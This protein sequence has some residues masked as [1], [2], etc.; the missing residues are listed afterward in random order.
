[1]AQPDE[2]SRKLIRKALNHLYNPDYLRR[3]PLIQLVGIAGRFDAPK[4][5]QRILIQ[6]IDTVQYRPAGSRDERRMYY[7]NLLHD[8]YVK[9]LGQEEVAV[10]LGVSLRQLAREQDHAVDILATVLA[11]KY[12]ALAST[13]SRQPLAISVQPPGAVSADLS[14]FAAET[15]DLPLRLSCE[16]E[17]ITNMIEPLLSQK[18]ISVETRLPPYTAG[19]MAHPVALRQALLVSIYAVLRGAGTKKILIEA[20]N[21][22]EQVQITIRAEGTTNVGNLPAQA[23]VE[24]VSRLVEMNG[25]WMDFIDTNDGSSAILSLPAFQHSLLLVID[26]DP[27]FLRFVEQSGQGSCYRIVSTPEPALAREW[28]IRYEIDF[29]MLD[30]MIARFD[31]WQLLK[32]L[33]EHPHAGKIPVVVCST[34]DLEEVAY[35]LGASAFLRKP[36]TREVLFAT[37][38]RLAG[39]LF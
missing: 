4:V 26:D 13:L 11:E 22:G 20:Q 36:I 30:V 5:L 15:P 7:Y 17:N 6:A 21:N 19:V 2:D 32:V 1:M 25:G 9:K 12:P 24:I 35:S 3:S 28:A 23:D 38:D 16:L 18:Q 37:L 29:I 39:G 14:R 27:N 8:R 10:R 33:H 31:G 34:I